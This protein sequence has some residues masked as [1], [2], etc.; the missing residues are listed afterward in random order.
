M[1]ISSYCASV[2]P[3]LLSATPPDVG[4]C[5]GGAAPVS[6]GTG[7]TVNDW[8]TKWTSTTRTFAGRCDPG[9]A[10]SFVNRD[11]VGARRWWG[12]PLPRAAR[13]VARAQCLPAPGALLSAAG[14]LLFAAGTLVST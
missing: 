6:A 5:A 14:A 13:R 11:G 10:I 8:G 1:T 3:V 4:E 9:G 2:L 7:G 12:A